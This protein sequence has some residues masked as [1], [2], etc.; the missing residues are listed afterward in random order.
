MKKILTLVTLV[1]LSLATAQA[2]NNQKMDH[3]KHEK[4]KKAYAL[5]HAN[6]MPNLMRVAM[7]NKDT[8]KLSK[9]QIKALKA[10]GDTNKPQMQKMIKKVMNQ[11]QRLLEESLTTDENIVQKAEKMLDTRREIIKMK[12][13][14]RENLKTILTPAQYA[15]VVSLYKN[16]GHKNKL[17]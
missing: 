2:Q 14:C 5:K 13:A 12:T 15:Q 4:M 6:P 11:E 3:A 16:S 9:E 7:K 17:K 8:L 10:W 1:A